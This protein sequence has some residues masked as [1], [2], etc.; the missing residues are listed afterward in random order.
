LTAY[1]D[2]PPA[3]VIEA[4]RDFAGT[5]KIP[6][7]QAYLTSIP[8]GSPYRLHSIFAQLGVTFIQCYGATGKDTADKKMISDMWKFYASFQRHSPHTKLRVILIS[9]DRDFA[10]VIGQLRNLGVEVGVL[11]GPQHSVSG[12]FDDYTVGMKV[13]P[14]LGVIEARTKGR[15]LS[16][17]RNPGNES[18]PPSRAVEGTEPYAR[19]VD[20][21]K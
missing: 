11:T 4:I 3:V 6:V 12:L 19:T 17:L 16:G 1:R 20:L 7:F 5:R 9:G 13:L 14:L 18:L 15:D 21:L 10:D 2:Q 8:F